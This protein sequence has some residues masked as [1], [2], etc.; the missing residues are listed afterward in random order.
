[1]NDD[2]DDVDEE[3]DEAKTKKTYVKSLSSH[4]VYTLLRVVYSTDQFIKHQY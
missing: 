2:D 1:M 4:I 3:D